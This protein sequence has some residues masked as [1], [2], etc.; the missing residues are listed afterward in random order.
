MTLDGPVRGTSPVRSTGQPCRRATLSSLSTAVLGAAFAPLLRPLS[1]GA[2]ELP[3][4]FPII[5]AQSQLAWLA[6]KD[7]VETFVT[8]RNKH[9]HTSIQHSPASCKH[10]PL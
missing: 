9:R 6:N 1:S 8:V 2:S 7:D 4:I 3:P 10:A 5:A